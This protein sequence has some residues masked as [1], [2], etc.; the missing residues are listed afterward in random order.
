MPLRR[1]GDTSRLSRVHAIASGPS[2][3]LMLGEQETK[4]GGTG[5]EGFVEALQVVGLIQP[6]ATGVEHGGGETAA[7]G[8][9][10]WERFDVGSSGLS[11]WT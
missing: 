8:P 11:R 2:G 1:V 4:L 7:G 10:R 6:V 5:E 3:A 9:P